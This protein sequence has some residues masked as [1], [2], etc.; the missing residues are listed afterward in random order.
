MNKEVSEKEDMSS[1]EIIKAA[2]HVHKQLGSGL[3]NKKH[4]EL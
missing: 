4:E 1:K 2:F 3:R